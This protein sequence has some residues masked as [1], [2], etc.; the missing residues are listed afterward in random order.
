[1]GYEDELKALQADGTLT[2]LNVAFSRTADKKDYV[3]DRILQM[4]TAIWKCLEA[5]GHIYVCGD[6]SKMAPDVR[7]SIKDVISE[8]S[9]MDSSAAG[10]LV[11][12]YCSVGEHRRYHEDV[13]AGN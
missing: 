12:Q 2:S 13:W 5:G 9:S 6:A 4:G 10:S 7:R 8:A 3:Q 1:M 11:D